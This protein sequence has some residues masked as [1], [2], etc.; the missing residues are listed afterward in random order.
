M[1]V[2]QLWINDSVIDLYPNTVIAQTFKAFE[3]GELNTKFRSSTNQFRVPPTENNDRV[4]GNARRI[5]SDTSIP[6]NVNTYRLIQNGNELPKGTP[7]IKQA[8]GEYSIFL[9]SGLSFFDTVGSKKLSDLDFTGGIN[10]VQTSAIPTATTARVTPVLNYGRFDLTTRY[11]TEEGYFSSFYYHTLIDKI[12]SGAG[13]SKSGAIF[14]NTK[15]LN[16]IVPYGMSKW[17]YSSDFLSARQAIAD[18]SV[19]QVIPWASLS[20]TDWTFPTLVSQGSLN[21]YN[22]GTSTYTPVDA[23]AAAAARLFGLTVLITVDI[24]V[25]GGT[26]DLEVNGSTSF[27]DLLSNVGTGVYTASVSNDSGRNGT[28]YT[29][30]ATGNTGTPSVTVN[31][32]RVSFI[33]TDVPAYGANGHV[34]HN[35]LLPNISQKDLLEDFS[36]RFGQMFKEVDKT[37]YCKSIDEIIL[38]RANAKDWTSKRVYNPKEPIKFTPSGLAKKN[39]FRYNNTDLQVSKDFAEAYIS[40]ANNNLKEEAEFIS[41]ASATDTKLQANIYMATPLLY[42][43]TQINFAEPFTYDNGFRVLLVRDKYSYEPTVSFDSGSSFL[44]SYKVAYFDDP[45][46][47][48]TCK[49]QQSIDNHYTQVSAAWQK[50]KLITREYNLTEADIQNLDIFVPVFDQDSYYIINSVGPYVPGEVTKVE[51]MKA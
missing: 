29:I 51:L 4:L 25:V 17:A 1:T 36:F 14:S 11:L 46:Q 15:Y 21:Y 40:I 19:A 8:G 3:L 5:Q 6:Y 2:N 43:N 44:T 45:A 47:T 23:D 34:Y 48:N 18:K 50:Y 12:F 24:T 38:D 13:F 35:Q 26:I 41:L 22:T 39:Y 32:G 33:P 49:W 30:R 7:V 37:V 42:D 27:F 16:T 9:L 20:T 10:G 31:S 28:G